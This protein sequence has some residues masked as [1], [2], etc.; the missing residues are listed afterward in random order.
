MIR[1]ESGPFRERHQNSGRFLG[2]WKCEA[3]REAGRTR[4]VRW[5]HPPRWSTCS[6]VLKVAVQ[7]ELELLGGGLERVL[8]RLAPQAHPLEHRL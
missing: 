7:V 2:G 3:K 6:H 8:R 1:D 4:R 5:R